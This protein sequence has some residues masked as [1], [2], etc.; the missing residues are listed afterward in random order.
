MVRILEEVEINPDG[1]K[2]AHAGDGIFLQSRSSPGATG[3]SADVKGTLTIVISTSEIV[4]FFQQTV[5]MFEAFGR[6]NPVIALFMKVG[7]WLR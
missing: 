2:I 4:M 3:G 1:R 7:A 5:E 6:W